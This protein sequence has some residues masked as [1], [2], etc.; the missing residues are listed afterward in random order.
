MEA[1]AL[2]TETNVDVVL[3]AVDITGTDVVELT[4]KVKL[5]SSHTVVIVLSSHADLAYCFTDHRGVACLRAGASGCLSKSV[6][7]TVLT[8]AVKLAPAE[9]CVFGLKCVGGILQ[10]LDGTDTKSQSAYMDLNHCEKQ[11]LTLAASEQYHG[12]RR[13]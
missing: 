6:S 7:H 10:A 2:V 4:K 5:Q 12:L 3:V 9:E 11:I 8:D 13:C 1:I